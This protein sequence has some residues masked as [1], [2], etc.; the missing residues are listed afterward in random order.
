MHKTVTIIGVIMVCGLFLYQPAIAGD[1]KKFSIGAIVSYYNTSSSEVGEV[2]ANFDTVPTIGLACTYHLNKFISLEL[3][4]QF[5]QTDLDVEH[6][7]K[8]GNLGKVKQIPILLTGRL[9]HLINNTNVSIYLGIGGGYFINDFDQNQRQDLAEFFGVNV[10]ADI[11]NSIGWLANV[12]AE[13]PFKDHYAVYADLK[14][15][16]NKAEFDLTYPDLTRDTK[17]VAL[18]A[19][20]FGVGFKYYF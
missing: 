13:M 2:D 8:S 5:I 7:D 19:S 11:N 12:G 16:F 6:D 4:S 9:Q 10:Q 20:I 3:S 1:A 17:D 14:V 15:I 18:N